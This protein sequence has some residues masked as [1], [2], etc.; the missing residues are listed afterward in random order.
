MRAVSKQ[1]WGTALGVSVLVAGCGGG[2]PQG[3]GQP[4]PVPVSLQEI[5]IRMVEESS[6]FVG[7][8]EAAQR[9]ILRPEIEGRV[10]N[11]FAENG[12]RVEAGTPIVQLRPDQQLAQVNSAVAQVNVRRA[13]L[14][15]AEAEVRAAQS[16]LAT[17]RAQR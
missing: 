11:I 15:S 17:A 13:G 8:L 10:V 7:N 2:P 9:V 5:E 12:T 3:R 14:L 6:E 1:I 4:G 16:Q